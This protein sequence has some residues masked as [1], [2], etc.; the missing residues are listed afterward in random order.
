MDKI[1]LLD[2]Y[3]PAADIVTA[4]ICLVMI[5]LVVFSYIS[6]TRSSKLFLSMVGLVLVASWVD[7][8][9]YMV[10][11]IPDQQILANWIRCAYHALLYLI[12]VHYIAYICEITQYEKQKLF[13]II[14]NI[15]FAVVLLAD[16]ITTV[17]G[18]TFSITET[19]VVFK[20]Q[21]LFFYAYACYLIL[22]L[23]LLAKVRKL[24]F[25]RVM[26]GFYGTI[27]ISMGILLLQGLTGQNSFTVAALL[28]PVVAMMYVLHSNPYDVM[29]GTNDIKV[30]RDLV[31]HYS[32][33]NKE[34]IFMSLYMRSFDEE[35]LELPKEIKT[36][37][38]QFTNQFFK[39]GRMF[40]AGKGHV[41]LLF[42]KGQNQNYEERINGMIEAFYPL[43]DHYQYD[44]K[45]VVGDS[46]ADIREA[47]DYLNYISEIHA[48]MP[49]CSVYRA[50]PEDVD[51]F[52]HSEYV[53]SE[54]ADIY[55][56]R[57]LNDPRVL[58]YYQPV[59]NARTGRFDTA[60][61]LMRLDLEKTGIVPPCLFIPLA[62]RQNYIH[63]LTEIILYKTCEAIRQF[64]D[65]GCDIK[66]ISVNVSAQELKDKDFCRDI[67]DII[68]SSGIY[69]NKIAIELT[70]S[71]TDSDFL[72]M[73]ETIEELKGNGIKFYLD[74]FGTG[75]SNMERIME[76]PFDIIKFDR[77]LVLAAGLNERSKKMVSNLAGMFSDMK[78]D[79]QYEGVENGSDEDM[80]RNMY[81][82]FL[83][84]FKYSKPVPVEELRG[85]IS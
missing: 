82:G 51:A 39:N 33:K 6:R 85:F 16:I 11:I 71:H 26:F 30:M 45:I 13:V 18:V 62:E 72:V 10:A 24:L 32:D 43:Y 75:Y 54:I 21:G 60:E 8:T 31:R 68:D 38:G 27:V 14:A 46:I 66:L 70:E 65:E 47:T 76:L 41:I 36:L 57:D 55:H 58:V 37:I 9:F 67:M 79:I 59:L 20:R 80:C 7:I 77:S 56:R 69:G 50:G 5:V 2:N 73:K 48:R 49:E 64:I 12:L 40:S 42:Q 81:A 4:A 84:G 19:S 34:F 3:S 53:L 28:L 78:Y 83:Q 25:R 15:V 52:R 44:Y 23:M 1:T 22:C 74:D 17:N 61:A 63:V 29:L 35:G